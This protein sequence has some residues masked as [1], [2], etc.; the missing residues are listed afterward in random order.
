MICDNKYLIFDTINIEKELKVC[1]IIIKI[2]VKVNKFSRLYDRYTKILPMARG[3][4]V[5]AIR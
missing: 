3:G 4:G 1:K 5:I 2:G